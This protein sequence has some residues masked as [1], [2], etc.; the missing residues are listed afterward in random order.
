[1]L[2]IW[3]RKNSI[4]VQKVMWIAGELGLAHERYDVGGP[5]GKNNEPEYLAL[6]PNGLV[7]TIQDGDFV[8]WESNAI[9]HYLAGKHENGKLLPSGAEAKARADQWM[10]WQ[11]LSYN[12]HITPIFIGIIRTPPE[13]RDMALIERSRKSVTDAAKILD[14][15]LAGSA[16]VAGD[17]FTIGDMPAAIT[18][19][20]Y[21]ALVPDRPELPHLKRWYDAIAARQPFRD[22]VAAVPLT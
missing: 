20:R 18:T 9:L 5:Y 12:T 1:M 11:Q 16:Y 10:D 22:H 7:P 15:H 2:K 17:R 6:N 13:K 8:L 19:Y 21:W 4:N 14:Q 3:G